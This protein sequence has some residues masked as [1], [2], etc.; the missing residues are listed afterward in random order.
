[1]SR[2]IQIAHSG[3]ARAEM[4]YFLKDLYGPCQVLDIQEL[5]TTRQ[6]VRYVRFKNDKTNKRHSL[7]LKH[8]SPLEEKIRR[9]QKN[10]GTPVPT[11]LSDE[12]VQLGEKNFLVMQDV[13]EPFASA[14]AIYEDEHRDELHEQLYDALQVVIAMNTNSECLAISELPTRGI[15]DLLPYR[16]FDPLQ[17]SCA[18]YPREPIGN[19]FCWGDAQP[20]NIVDACAVDR[21]NP[22]KLLDWELSHYGP[23]PCD[24]AMWAVASSYLRA[25]DP[26]ATLS[27]IEEIQTHFDTQ[28]GSAKNA[29]YD[30]VLNSCV[31]KIGD[32]AAMLQRTKDDER[33]TRMKWFASLYVLLS[34]NVY[35]KNPTLKKE[36]VFSMLQSSKY[37]NLFEE[38]IPSI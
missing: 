37:R 38:V 35:P 24:V 10:I 23:S 12:P 1:M 5:R 4:Y 17:A 11:L 32:N 26:D 28:Y 13:G 14:F 8:C 6:D 36:D 18:L 29:Y 9:L 21:C 16:V 2:L 25:D 34:N 30:D 7:Y 27:F 31:L 20:F 3:D 19:F 15:V 22:L 33:K